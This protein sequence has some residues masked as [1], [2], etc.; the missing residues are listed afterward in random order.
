MGK[1]CPS[2]QQTALVFTD[3]FMA[4]GGE[5]GLLS[6]SWNYLSHFES[7]KG[8]RHTYLRTTDRHKGREPLLRTVKVAV[9]LG[10][11]GQV[12]FPNKFHSVI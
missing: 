2:W 4:S 5:H 3:D 7:W 10:L 9:V 12:L 8:N 11:A 6:W 1:S